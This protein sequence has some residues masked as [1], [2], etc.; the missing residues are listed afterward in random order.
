MSD[1]YA[2]LQK[3]AD[4]GSIQF[5]ANVDGGWIKVYFEIDGVRGECQFSPDN[6]GLY[7]LG[8][9]EPGPFLEMMLKAREET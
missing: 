7:A 2:Q 9:F 5:D 8:F 3:L 4:P 6:T 1:T